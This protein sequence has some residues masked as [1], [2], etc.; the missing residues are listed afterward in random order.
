MHIALPA[1]LQRH[2]ILRGKGMD[3]NIT[4]PARIEPS[5][6]IQVLKKKKKNAGG[7]REKDNL[8][9]LMGAPNESLNVDA[10]G[11]SFQRYSYSPYYSHS[12]SN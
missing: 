2:G 3:Q 5:A 7:N 4:R 1:L 8:H 11:H 10:R 12:P 9:G 6:N